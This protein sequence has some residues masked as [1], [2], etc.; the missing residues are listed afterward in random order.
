MWRMLLK[1]IDWFVPANDRRE[2]SELGLARVFIFTH[3][4]GPLLAQSISLFLYLTDPKPGFA[5]WTMIIAIWSFWTLPFLLK[6]TRNLQLVAFLSVEVLAF[7]SLFGSFHYG[8]VSSPLLPWLLIALLLGFFYLG[9][10]PVLVLGLFSVDLL[11]FFGAY[12]LNH[13]FDQRVPLSALT[14]VG[15]ISIMSATVYMSW[16]A[17]Y[18]VGVIALNSDLER[19]AERHR[20][21]AVRLRKAKDFAERANLSRSIFL[22]KMSHEFRTPLN[23]VIGY[24]ELLLEH[25]QDSGASE[26]ELVDLGRINAAGRHLLSLVTDVLDLS[27]IESNSVELSVESFSLEG[28]IREVAATAMPLINENDN[29]LVVKVGSYLSQIS[30]D[31]TK[32]RQVIFNLLSNAAKFTSRGTITVSASRESHPGGDWIE[33]AVEDT[34]IGIA[35]ADLAKLFEEFRQVGA[36]TYG[37][38]GGTGLGLAVSQKLCALM[39]GGISVNSEAGHGS[40][41]TIRL[42]A[43]LTADLSPAVAEPALVP[44]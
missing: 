27:R 7:A 28:F 38:Y 43:A 20:T 35:Q 15:W 17:I 26:Q 9:D 5:V 29:R 19:E 18:Y 24:S 11:G 34:G 6:F 16:M 37:K 33:I 13:G 32:L 14:A 31:P 22:A 1:L 40:A 25:G 3:L 2:R 44:G 23:A 39:G 10:R 36:S 42:P 30:T 12:L 41:F 8:G 4:F 21:T